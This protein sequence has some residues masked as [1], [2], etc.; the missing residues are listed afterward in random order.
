MSVG[1]AL[2][3]LA[4]RRSLER[5]PPIR[6]A[7][8]STG[9]PPRPDGHRHWHRRDSR[10]SRRRAVR[11][12][13]HREGAARR[14]RAPPGV[15]PRSRATTSPQTCV[16]SASRRPTSSCGRCV[17]SWAAPSSGSRAASWLP[18]SVG[19][20]ASTPSSHFGCSRSSLR[21]SRAFSPGTGALVVHLECRWAGVHPDMAPPAPP[22]GV[23]AV[24]MSGYLTSAR[25]RESSPTTRGTTIQIVVVEPSIAHSSPVFVAP[26]KSC[27]CV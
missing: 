18:D 21:G 22:A 23:P 9:R 24:G 25:R 19:I 26:S 8:A 13:L 7:G 10:L 16:A 12:G 11:T 4:G 2:V 27:T 17:R 1:F 6:S 20:D 15:D 14:H 3:C 5:E